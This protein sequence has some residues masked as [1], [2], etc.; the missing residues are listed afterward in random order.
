MLIFEFLQKSMSRNSIPNDWHRR[1]KY[2]TIKKLLKAFPKTNSHVGIKSP[3]L[4]FLGRDV[5]IKPYQNQYQISK[6][7]SKSGGI[8]KSISKS[9]LNIELIK[10]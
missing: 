3:P 9:S 6:S 10:V 7:I 5:K 2:V 1:I 8:S 4:H